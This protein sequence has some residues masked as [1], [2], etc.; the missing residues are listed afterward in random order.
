MMLMYNSPFYIGG[1]I[2]WGGESLCELTT[3]MSQCFPQRLFGNS[4]LMFLS[5]KAVVELKTTLG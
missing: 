5:D 4:W 2:G 3:I 1:G